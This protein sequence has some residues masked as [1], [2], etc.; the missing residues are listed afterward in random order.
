MLASDRAAAASD[1]RAIPWPTSTG[2][3][4]ARPRGGADNPATGAPRTQL[5]RD[6]AHGVQLPPEPED[7][8]AAIMQATFA[9]VAWKGSKAAANRV[10][11]AA[12]F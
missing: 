9:N 2:N 11:F 12:D 6:H 7:D 8:A 1:S 5:A 4:G 10:S 3:L